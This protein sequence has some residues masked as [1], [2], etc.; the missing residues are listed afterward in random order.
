MN[1]KRSRAKAMAV[2]AGWA[3]YLVDRVDG[4]EY[5]VVPIDDE[6]GHFVPVDGAPCECWCKPDVDDNTI[7]HHSLDHRELTERRS[8]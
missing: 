7:V 4:P 5:H 8:H 2:S 6:R 1:T 3:V